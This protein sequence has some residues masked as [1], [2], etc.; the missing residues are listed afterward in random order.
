MKTFFSFVCS[1]FFCILFLFSSLT[2]QAQKADIYA[3]Q[4]TVDFVNKISSK[5]SSHP[6]RELDTTRLGARKAS[7]INNSFFSKGA[8]NRYIASQTVRYLTG[9]ED[10]SYYDTYITASSADG[11]MNVG[12]TKTYKDTADERVKSVWNYGLKTKVLSG[13]GNLFSDRKFS[14]DVGVYS[15]FTVFGKGKIFFFGSKSDSMANE[16]IYIENTIAV[17]IQEEAADFAKKQK[18]AL[19]LFDNN[20]PKGDRKEFLESQKRDLLAF[21][22]AQ[23]KKFKERY[24][25][26][27]L[28]AGKPRVN[29]L[30][31][32]WWT[33]RATAAASSYSVT[34]DSL[35]APA[36]KYFFPLSVGI[37]YSVFAEDFREGK[38]RWRRL[39]SLLTFSADVRN[40]NQLRQIDRFGKDAAA[41]LEGK[42]VEKDGVTHWQGPYDTWAEVNF[43]ARALLALPKVSKIVSLDL[44]FDYTAGRYHTQNLGLGVLF[45]LPGQDKKTNINLEVLAQFIDIDRTL[46]PGK[47]ALDR[48]KV[49][50]SLALPLNSNLN[51][52]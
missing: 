3:P 19:D 4:K 11:S 22:K 38:W 34:T 24:F 17:D 35:T 8:L 43:Q 13:I 21:N 51:N 23:D 6:Y 50:L 42:N 5:T 25:E 30:R 47:D 15:N 39:R 41:K 36:A 52:L 28:A 27:E 12:R 16:R 32:S 46:L 44:L 20:Q 31:Q 29:Y 10:V 14:R 49:G 45:V 7:W 26:M 37:S 9:K 48:L 2:I 1:A 40:T 33:P 18:Q